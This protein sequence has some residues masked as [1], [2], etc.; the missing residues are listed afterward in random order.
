MSGVDGS[1]VP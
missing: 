1:I